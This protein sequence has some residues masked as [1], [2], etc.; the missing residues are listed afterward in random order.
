MKQYKDHAIV[1]SRIDYA[2]RDRILTLLCEEQGKVSVLA[3]GVR[4]Q[5]SRLAG[6]IELLSE[7]EVNFID[8][9]SNLKTL[10]GARLRVHFSD[11]ARDMRRMNQAFSFI[12]TVNGI[13]EEGT[14]QE[15]Y[16][17]LLEGFAALNDPSRD[18]H[19]IEIWFNLQILYKS[20]SVPNLAAGAADSYEFDYE[21]QSFIARDKGAFTKNDLKLLRLCVSQT[22]PPKLS[23]ELGSEDRLQSLTRS[24]L[25]MNVTEV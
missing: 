24:L 5:K 1:L 7:S 18:A 17:T 3:K 20:G 10:T 19:V 14:G 4:A 21:S 25:K 9:R 12:K 8:T 13:T 11:L 15:L 22:R 23:N 6:G 16:L 2:E